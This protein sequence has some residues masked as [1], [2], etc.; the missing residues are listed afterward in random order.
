ME[1]NCKFPTKEGDVPFKIGETLACSSKPEQGAT[2]TAVLIEKKKRLTP[3]NVSV[4]PQYPNP[5]QQELPNLTWTRGKDG[6]IGQ[7][8]KVGKQIN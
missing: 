8:W 2:T 5:T 1:I 3:S 4:P 7:S 6:R